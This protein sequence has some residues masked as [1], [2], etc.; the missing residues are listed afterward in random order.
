MRKHL[1]GQFIKKGLSYPKDDPE[2]L[3]DLERVQEIWHEGLKKWA[4]PFLC[5]EK[6]SA[7]DAMFAP[8]GLGRFIPY[9]VKLDTTLANYVKLIADLPSVKEWMAAANK[10]MSS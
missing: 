6:F 9:E 1:S 7:V 4:G 10:E 8:V 2:V 3:A 5:G